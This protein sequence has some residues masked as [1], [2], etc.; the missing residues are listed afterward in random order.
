MQ[1]ASIIGT[2]ETTALLTEAGTVSKTVYSIEIPYLNGW[3][4]ENTI[5]HVFLDS[6]PE[7]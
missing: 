2:D 5:L 6:S 4:P 7:Q 3:S 1:S